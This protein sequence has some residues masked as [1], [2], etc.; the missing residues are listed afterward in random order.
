MQLIWEKAKDF[1]TKA[2]TIIFLATIVI[3]FLQ[4]FDVRLNVVTDSKDSLLALI[5]G[6]IAPVFAPL[7]FNDWNFYSTYYGIY[8]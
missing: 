6:L 1:I 5:G 8:S 3:W 7:G 4:T 2:F